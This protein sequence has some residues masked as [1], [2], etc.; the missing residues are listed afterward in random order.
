MKDIIEDMRLIQAKTLEWTGGALDLQMEFYELP[1]DFT[2]FTAPDF[3]I[4]PFEVDDEFLNDYVTTRTRISSTW[5]TVSR[6]APVSRQLAY[7]CGSLL[8]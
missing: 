7:E 1:V 6:I 4:G 8:R 3:I 2:G 5:S